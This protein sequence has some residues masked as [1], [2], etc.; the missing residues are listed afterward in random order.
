MIQRHMGLSVRANRTE[1]PDALCTTGPFRYSRN[2]IYLAFIGPLAALGYYS[3]LA[4]AASIVAYVLST[5]RF[6]IR[7]EEQSLRAKFGAS[8]ESYRSRTPRWIFFS[9]R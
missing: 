1:M 2:P 8:F 6:V 9:E 5:T 3:P 7:D 4:A